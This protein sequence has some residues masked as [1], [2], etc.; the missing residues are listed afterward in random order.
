MILSYSYIYTVL[1][2]LFFGAPQR[3]PRLLRQYFDADGSSSW[4]LLKHGSRAWP[5][6][7][8]NYQ[9]R[10]GW[11]IFRSAHGLGVDYKLTLAC[12]HRW[13][14]HTIMFDRRDKELVFD[15]SGPNGYWQDIH[16]P[17]GEC[18]CLLSNNNYML[19]NIALLVSFN[20]STFANIT[21]MPLNC[22]FLYRS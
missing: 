15:W 14:F 22:W 3:L 6:E 7:V 19:R 17:A 4:I 9:F 1:L 5:V 16:P 13:I 20:H 12:E 11:D 2:L 21:L 8:V 18:D 10:N